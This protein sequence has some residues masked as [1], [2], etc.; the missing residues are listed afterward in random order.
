MKKILICILT[1]LN[2]NLIWAQD[3]DVNLYTGQANI[4]IPIW[5][6]TSKDLAHPIGLNYNASG[7]KVDL[8]S[9]KAGIGWHLSAGGLVTRELRGL[10]DEY[11]SSGTDA[12]SGWLDGNHTLIGNKTFQGDSDFTTSADEAADWIAL[13][14]LGLYG[15]TMIDT[16]PDLFHINTAGLNLTFMFDNA[17]DIV[18]IPYQDVEIGYGLDSNGKID[19]IGVIDSRGAHYNFERAVGSTI[20]AS[21]LSGA[22]DH[23][24]SR[25]VDL[26]QNAIEYNSIWHLT[27][28]SS[29][30]QGKINFLYNNTPKYDA[31][32]SQTGYYY[33]S[34]PETS[35]DSITY[36]VHDTE[37]QYRVDTM[38]VYN[39]TNARP[40]DLDRII[41]E[42]VII[43]FE[44]ALE[45]LPVQI[46]PK[47]K[48]EFYKDV[49]VMT[50]RP[51]LNKISIHG[52]SGFS[53]DRQFLF[54]YKHV[55]NFENPLLGKTHPFLRSV[56]QHTNGYTLPSYKFDYMGVNFDTGIAFLPKPNS[57]RK[58]F[59][60]YFNNRG[61]HALNQE[62]LKLY[63]Y[64][65]LDN[66]DRYRFWPINGYTGEVHTFS[67]RDGSLNPNTVA[68]GTISKINLP[69]GGH[70]SYYYEPNYFYDTLSGFD[71][72]GG[73]LRVKKVVRHDGISFDNDIKKHFSYKKSSGTSSGKLLYRPQYAMTRTYH[74]DTA[75]TLETYEDMVS[76]GMD[77]KTIWQ[78]ITVRSENDM[79]RAN[80]PAVGYQKVAVS[81]D[82]L[83]RVEYD[84]DIFEDFTG[85]QSTAA[86]RVARQA[87]SSGTLVAN[88]FT[89]LLSAHSYPYGPAPGIGH[90]RGLLSKSSIFAENGFLLETTESNYTYL[91]AEYYVKAL[92]VERLPYNRETIVSGNSSFVI[93]NAYVYSDYQVT[94]SVSPVMTSSVNTKYN[95]NSLGLSIVS[96]T[97]MEYSTS[98]GELFLTK[99]TSQNGQGKQYST[100]YT[101]AKDYTNPNNLLAGPNLRALLK[102]QQKHMNHV[103]VET[104]SKVTLPGDSTKVMGAAISL[105]EYGN[106][107]YVNVVETKILSAPNGIT[108][109][110]PVSLKEAIGTLK[111]DADTRFETVLVNEIFDDQ[112]RAVSS[113]DRAGNYVATLFDGTGKIPVA[114]VSGAKKSEVF[115]MDFENPNITSEDHEFDF[116]HTVIFNADLLNEGRNGNK[117]YDIKS[118]NSHRLFKDGVDLADE[119][120]LFSLWAHEHASP[121]NG[122]VTLTITLT[123]STT[124]VQTISIPHNNDWTYYETILDSKDLTGLTNIKIT[125]SEKIRLDDVLMHPVSASMKYNQFNSKRQLIGETASGVS[126]YYQYDHLGRAKS[127]KDHEGNII[128]IN[129]YHTREPATDLYISALDATLNASFRAYHSKLVNPS[130]KWTVIENINNTTDY[131]PSTYDFS[132]IANGT[133]T[134]SHL[135]PST[136]SN[137]YV[138]LQLSADGISPKY[139]KIQVRGEGLSNEQE[140]F[141]L[142]VGGPIRYDRC[143]EEPSVMGRCSFPM[144]LIS[145]TVFVAHLPDVGANS[146]VYT[147]KRL[148]KSNYDVHGTSSAFTQTLLETGNELGIVISDY[149]SE[150]FYIWCSAVAYNSNNESIATYQSNVQHIQVYN[151]QISCSPAE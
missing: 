110:V 112:N 73:G 41:A 38:H 80:G 102:L 122:T 94:T 141:T 11:T 135:F 5:T 22:D 74:L 89:P 39:V 6:A 68:N 28:M 126:I 77:S 48:A 134:F 88:T 128:N 55:K 67:G 18:T 3:G 51:L 13:N 54:Q 45:Y 23:L 116:D 50:P 56:T 71:R 75:G 104:V 111:F 47:D 59:F 107:D 30:A 40:L 118:D 20:S 82:G 58:D 144:Q 129:E 115:F 140:A 150:D 25:D 96:T 99:R 66:A 12:R 120:Y 95:E 31:S 26:Y 21:K 37:N 52:I 100:E 101:Y 69:T 131:D 93:A 44:D 109:Y 14:A 24:F 64:P 61:A 146:T 27:A 7:V 130:Y 62:L 84:F 86:T 137:H 1:I 10:P 142:C 9:G 35:E 133:S 151:S 57:P 143:E 136:D 148:N 139:T 49:T 114:S 103:P 8:V 124:K 113:H 15:N 4:G 34:I 81:Q 42:D 147:W 43:S 46:I 60:G 87:P 83:G 65:D 127:T 117:A 76:A 91:P 90:K 97:T 92:K 17:G 63:V 132:G 121:Y 2:I 125:T 36:Y 119:P 123:G 70:I 29:P 78:K 108:D 19:S 72:Y 106:N 105:F 149:G 85:A 16:E 138:Y 98:G 79:G 53:L 33:V 145:G 32:F